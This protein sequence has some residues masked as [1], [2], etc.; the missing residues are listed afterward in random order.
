MIARTTEK[1]LY[2]IV[3]CQG[4]LPKTSTKSVTACARVTLGIHLIYFHLIIHSK[5]YMLSKIHD[6]QNQ[7]EIMEF[8]S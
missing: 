8:I 1:E 3:F 5:F 7:F 4:D 6:I 2:D